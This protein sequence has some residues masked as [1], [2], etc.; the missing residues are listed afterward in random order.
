MKMVSINF[1]L[2]KRRDKDGRLKK[3]NVP[4]LMFF[5]YDGRRLQMNTGE[6]TDFEKWDFKKQKIIDKIPQSEQINGTLTSLADEIM[7]IYR[8]AK[9]MGIEPGNVYLREKLKNRK[10]H[11]GHY[12]FD[13][14]MKFI[15]EKNEKWSIHTFRKIETNYRHLR[16]FSEK[17]GYLIDFEKINEDFFNKY[18]SYFHDKGHTNSTIVKNLNVLKWFLNWATWRGFNKN[19]YYRDFRFPWDHSYKTNPAD[20]YLKWDELMNL[21]RA[22]IADNQLCEARDIFC[23]M[24]FTGLKHSQL[25]V[26]NKNGNIHNNI[27]SFKLKVRNIKC[28]PFDKYLKELLKR[29][30]Q[31]GSGRTGLPDIRNV[32][33][34]RLIKTAGRTAGLYQP[35]KIQ[36]CNGHEKRTRDIPKYKLLSTRLARNTFIFHSLRLGLPLQH[37]LSVTGLKTLYGIRRFYN[38][39]NSS[40]KPEIISVLTN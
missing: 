4:V 24:C 40:S 18:I 25:R 3:Q 17:S 2:E 12:F 23:F 37:I 29:Y 21:Y 20:Q 10:I 1:Y 38:I 14:Y 31:E 35:I 28:T 15:E 16:D 39:T 32:K 27:N 6:K 9:Q 36:I 8:N 7:S 26:L 5:S 33:M 13:I 22:E 19:L 11:P 30:Y 34:N